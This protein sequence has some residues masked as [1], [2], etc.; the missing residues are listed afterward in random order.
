MK[1]TAENKTCLVVVGGLPATG[2]TALSRPLARELGGVHLRI[3]TIEQA[4]V[5][6]GL[7]D[8]LEG[9]A[10]YE[11]AYALAHDHLAA[12]LHVVAECVNPMK[13]T[14][15][16]WRDVADHSSSRLVEVELVCSDVAEH[17]RRA[18]TRSIDVPG[19]APPTWKQIVDREYEP[20]DRP[21]VVIDTSGR[22]AA[23]CIEA[24]RH[25]VAQ[26]VTPR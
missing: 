6:S 26:R 22:T 24:L 5:R 17:R 9:P 20:W 2:K 16:A 12:G 25:E 14:R 8:R 18:T 10:G 15:D 7:V 13:V 21:H 23:E 4:I 11:V 1:R 3:D 19:L